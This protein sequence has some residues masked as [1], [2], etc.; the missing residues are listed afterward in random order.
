MNQVYW[1]DITYIIIIFRTGFILDH[2]KYLNGR[3]TMKSI[4]GPEKLGINVNSL[5]VRSVK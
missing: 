4:S 5:K 2:N 3:A 1:V